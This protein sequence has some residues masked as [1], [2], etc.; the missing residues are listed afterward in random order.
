MVSGG[1]SLFFL[2][3]ALVQMARLYR[4][5]GPTAARSWFLTFLFAMAGVAFA[6]ATGGDP[7]GLA[8]VLIGACLA[9]GGIALY[10]AAHAQRLLLEKPEEAQQHGS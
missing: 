2:A 1:A 5:T 7:L 10:N 8:P 6:G 3:W 9:A 4:T